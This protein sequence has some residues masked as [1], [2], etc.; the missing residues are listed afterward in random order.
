MSYLAAF[1]R[2]CLPRFTGILTRETVLRAV[3]LWDPHW[4]DNARIFPEVFETSRAIRIELERHA[5]GFYRQLL[6][7]GFGCAP[8]TLPTPL[9]RAIRKAAKTP[10]KEAEA[11][12]D[13][14]PPLGIEA[15]LKE[16][17]ISPYELSLASPI[18]GR[19]PKGADILPR[20]LLAWWLLGLDED[21]ML[22][23][24]KRSGTVMGRE[25]LYKWMGSVIKPSGAFQYWVVS[26]N[27]AAFYRLQIHQRKRKPYIR[28]QLRSGKQFIP[29]PRKSFRKPMLF[30]SLD[31]KRV[32]LEG[33]SASAQRHLALIGKVNGWK[34]F[35][36]PP[37]Y[38]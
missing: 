5:K 8:P 14:G 32:W 22:F 33:N 6:L 3:S 31:H 19:N 15:A 1:G 18:I 10:S 20:S 24:L 26:P 23:R 36:E 16:R 12:P 13:R 7:P 29:E 27:D 11:R 21:Y 9:S 37:R 2:I 34:R 30:E 38:R 25:E 4:N 28:A 35:K 17:P